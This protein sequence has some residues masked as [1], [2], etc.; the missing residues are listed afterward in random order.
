MRRGRIAC[1]V[2]LVLM[3]MASVHAAEPGRASPGAAVQTSQADVQ[4]TDT[5]APQS[6]AQA[7]WK[8]HCGPCHLEGGT[9]TFMLG[10]RLGPERALL[11]QRTDLN[12]QYVR[13]VVRHGIQSMPRFSRV[14]LPD[15]DLERI[16]QYL[17]AAGDR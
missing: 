14:E 9:G 4:S 1:A 13:T 11:E 10:R 12:A 7:L 8:R 3:V 16:A 2:P 6:R 17:S 5:N 15:E